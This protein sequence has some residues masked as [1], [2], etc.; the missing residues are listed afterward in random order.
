M[1]ANG[2]R[3]VKSCSGTRGLGGFVS[4]P[5]HVAQGGRLSVNTVRSDGSLNGSDDVFIG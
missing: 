4:E 2:Y 3:V 1:F 5:L